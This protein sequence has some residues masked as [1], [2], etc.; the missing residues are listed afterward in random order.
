MAYQACEDCGTRMYGGTCSN[1]QEELV[2]YEADSDFNYS[3]DFMALVVEQETTRA[4]RPTRHE[5][6]PEE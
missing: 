2:I 6:Q 1:C 3:D 4:N 5:A